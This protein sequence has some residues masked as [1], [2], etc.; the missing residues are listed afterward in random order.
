MLFI[1]NECDWTLLVKTIYSHNYYRLIHTTYLYT[2][3]L[4]LHM[5]AYKITLTEVPNITNTSQDER[6]HLVGEENLM[7]TCEFEGFPLPSISFYFNGVCITVDSTNGIIIVGNTLT[8]PSPQVSHSGVYQ[9][10]V[11]NEFGD[12]QAAWLLEIRQPSE[13]T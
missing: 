3:S 2:E 9:C 4:R 10:I 8:I 5:H 11:S 13:F 12:D 7:Y 6:E 1:S